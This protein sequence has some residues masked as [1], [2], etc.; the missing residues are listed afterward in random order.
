MDWKALGQTILVCGVLVLSGA[1][2]AAA[3]INAS[4][5]TSHCHLVKKRLTQYQ[6]CLRTPGCLVN[7]DDLRFY[8][9]QRAVYHDD[10]IKRGWHDKT[11]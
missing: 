11:S 8:E 2:I 6:T 3:I 7:L 10:C 1:G 5:S 4:E 9:K